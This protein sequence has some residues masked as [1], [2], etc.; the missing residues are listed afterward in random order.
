M[1]IH[2]KGSLP[3][4]VYTS[5]YPPPFNIPDGLARGRSIGD[6][7]GLTQFGIHEETLEPGGVSAHRH[8]HEQEDEAAYILGGCVTLVDDDG[9]HD[10]YPGD[11]VTF[12][13]G[14]ANGHHLVNNSSAP[15]TYLIIGSRLPDEV[16]HYPDID[17]LLT[18][19][20]G[21]SRFTHKDGSAIKEQSDAQD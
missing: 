5:P 2:R 16:A 4:D 3:E 15:A 12:K 13:A 21:K 19:V 17:L 18:R 1:P 7:G 20:A 8:W 11:A 6:A 10:L 9:A 14:A